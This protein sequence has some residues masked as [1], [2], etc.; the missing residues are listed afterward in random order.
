MK[1]KII[2]NKNKGI[3]FWVTG[4]SGSGKTKIS[5][6]ILKKISKLYGP[7]IEV[8]GDEWR[9]VTNFKKYDKKSRIEGL[10]RLHR[11][12]KMIT[13]KKINLILN[14]IGMYNRAR[15]WN[16]LNIDNYVE[17]Y[18]EADLKK[19]IYLKKKPIYLTNKK[20]IVGL[21]IKAELP[22]NPHIKIVNPL[23]KPLDNLA[24]ELLLKIKKLVIT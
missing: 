5:K 2:I 8:S 9:G 20:N 18:I 21:D 23:N 4:F 3:L 15:K 6:K 14:C 1:K 7:T 24:K 19:I 12:T 16:R 22:K 17:I 13:D 10:L 11:F